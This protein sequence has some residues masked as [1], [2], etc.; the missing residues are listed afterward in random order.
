MA[1]SESEMRETM[2]TSATQI[3][4]E[5]RWEGRY[6]IQEQVTISGAAGAGA[7]GAAEVLSELRF[8]SFHVWFL[9]TES[10]HETQSVQV[11]GKMH[12]NIRI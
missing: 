11:A 6:G 12:T 5:E 4:T 10:C 8:S 3:R 7:A 2:V 1:S 9:P